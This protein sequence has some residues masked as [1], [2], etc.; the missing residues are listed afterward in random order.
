MGLCVWAV[1][2]GLVYV[3]VA[4]NSFPG[5]VVVVTGLIGIIILNRWLIYINEPKE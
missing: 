2:I 1:I 4:E 5:L 3:V